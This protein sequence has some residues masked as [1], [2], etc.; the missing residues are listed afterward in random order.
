MRW[1]LNMAV[2]VSLF[3][4]IATLVVWHESHDYG[5]IYSNDPW[6]ITL[7][8]GDL[9]VEQSNMLLGGTELGISIE[10]FDP[11][12]NIRELAPWAYGEKQ[13]SIGHVDYYDVEF[14][15]TGPT[16]GVFFGQALI[17]PLGYLAVLFA[18]LPLLW[19]VWL[20]KRSRS[21]RVRRGLCGAC[22]YDL[23][24]STNK[25]AACPECGATP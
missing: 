1:I 2:A 17:V 6:R 12:M 25:A 18:I 9:M 14:T 4:L 10:H 21:H 22:G 16:P 3:L 19:L 23:R 7:I 11:P 13:W 24:G 15:L 20:R 5:M 8:D